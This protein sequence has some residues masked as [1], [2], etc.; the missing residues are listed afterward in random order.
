LKCDVE[1]VGTAVNREWT[2]W[3]V[4]TNTD[5]VFQISDIR[6]KRGMDGVSHISNLKLQISDIKAQISYF[7]FE[8]ED[9]TL[10]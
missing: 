5:E 8:K 2:L 1:G 3:T 6:K 9:C 7:R 4:W 10:K